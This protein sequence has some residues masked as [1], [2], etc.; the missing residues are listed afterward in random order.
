[1]LFVISDSVLSYDMFVAELPYSHSIIMLTYYSAQL[2]IT[3]S[4]VN[5]CESQVIHWK[6]M[7]ECFKYVNNKNQKKE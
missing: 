4:V 7:I 5:S 2:G 3:L 1:M 6:D